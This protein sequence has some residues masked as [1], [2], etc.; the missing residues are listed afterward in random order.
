MRVILVLALLM[1]ALFVPVFSEH[2]F[3]GAIG[4]V[5]A[6][7]NGEVLYA[8]QISYSEEEGGLRPGANFSYSRGPAYIREE[9]PLP[10]EARLVN[11][12][13]KPQ[14]FTLVMLLDNLQ[15]E[16]PLDGRAGTVHQVQLEA[17]GEEILSAEL[18][19][20]E[21]GLHNLFLICL[22]HLQGDAAEAAGHFPPYVES[23]FNG[24]GRP[25]RITAARPAE[26]EFLHGNRGHRL[27]RVLPQGGLAVST[28]RY[29][30]EE[31]L[32]SELEL[33]PGEEFTY[34]IQMRN[35][36]TAPRAEEFSI[37]ALLDG[38]QIP[39][40]GDEEH[41]VM[42]LC[43]PAGYE[44][45]LKAELTAPTTPGGH[46]LWLL[47]LGNP[48]ARRDSGLG[49]SLPYSLRLKVKVG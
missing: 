24:E 19:L 3:S 15:V 48:Y 46:E 26:E 9:E 41:P 32:L 16:F 12:T 33:Q 42:N 25:P 21:E 13:P 38:V 44:I 45:A 1:S 47:A 39:V 8:A 7:S 30:A 49:P 40:G 5:V 18:P 14:E 6:D 27:T 29:P 4:F 11:G 22:Y 37:V 36:P 31:E 10:R 17:S 23:L 35:D 2:G 28:E 20:V 34:Y 43:L